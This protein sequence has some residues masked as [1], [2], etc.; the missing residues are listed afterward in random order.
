ME[1][2]PAPVN[3]QHA[4]K[5]PSHEEAQLAL[6]LET[7]RT[8]LEMIEAREGRGGRV[9]YYLRHQYVTEKLNDLCG[10]DWDFRVLRERM[11]EDNI[12]VL[13]ELTVRVAG[14]VIVKSQYGSDTV[15]RFTDGP[16]KGKP[17]S[18][19][20][21]FKAAASDA[22]KKCATL[23]GL[24]LDL[25]MPIQDATRKALHATGKEAFG[26]EWDAKRHYAVRVLTG[27]RKTSSND[28]MDVEARILTAV[29]NGDLASEAAQA[30]AS[31]LKPQNNRR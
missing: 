30:F 18:I 14:R 31:K 24:G 17:L 21:N 1:T 9:F 16:N 11:D 10:R 13:G 27:G 7:Q 26:D 20:D 15:E 3:H 6:W 8:P 5:P 23:I 12:T 19:G 2:L 22:L 29:L 25:S 28:L 4:I